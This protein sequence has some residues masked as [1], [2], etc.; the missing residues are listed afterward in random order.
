MT[1]DE[2]FQVL[3]ETL[4]VDPGIREQLGAT[5]EFDK[6]FDLTIEIA[7]SGQQAYLHAPVT[8]V[9]IEKR[10]D[11][12]A[13]ALQLHMFGLATEGN[14]FGY[15]MQRSRLILFRVLDL[16]ILP[17]STVPELIES[18]VNQLESWTHYFFQLDLNHARAANGK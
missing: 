18:F 9:P 11:L 2:F 13:L 14:T 12:F 4:H 1:S 5:V 8:S 17:A 6:R 7:E 16:P 10:D 15:D 3:V